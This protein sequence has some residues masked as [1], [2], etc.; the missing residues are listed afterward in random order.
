[1]KAVLCPVCGR[2]CFCL[3]RKI[4]VPPKA[5]IADWATI[6]GQ[7]RGTKAQVARRHEVEKRI[8][9]L[10]SLPEAPS[11]NYH[12]KKLREELVEG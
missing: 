5:K 11:R 6:A 2:E 3:G 8:R 9:E 10:E 4:P 7:V 12:L 1:V